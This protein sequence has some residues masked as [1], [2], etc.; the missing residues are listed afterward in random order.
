MDLTRRFRLDKLFRQPVLDDPTAL[1]WGI[2]LE[3]FLR[4]KARKTNV[5]I[6]N[7]TSHFLASPD[8]L[9]QEV[10]STVTIEELPDVGTDMP[11]PSGT[12]L[13]PPKS[14]VLPQTDVNKDIPPLNDAPLIDDKP[15]AT[16]SPAQR[17]P[18]TSNHIGDSVNDGDAFKGDDDDDAASLA[19]DKD[20]DSEGS[21][22]VVDEKEN[23]TSDAAV[24]VASGS[25]GSVEAPAD[26]VVVVDEKENDTS[27]AASR[28]KRRA[29][30]GERTLAK[31]QKGKAE[32]NLKEEQIYKSTQEAIGNLR[33]GMKEARDNGT[34]MLLQE[35]DDEI[36]RVNDDLNTDLINSCETVQDVLAVVAKF[37]TLKAH[38]A[39]CEK[40]MKVMMDSVTG[41]KS[42]KRSTKKTSQ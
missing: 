11:N 39:A 27:N 22:F 33:R 37:E 8:E 2:V 30:D 6:A 26:F 13:T 40:K 35:D 20:D 28:N 24:A 19:D 9:L 38:K 7:T 42:T 15:P 4:A 34:L 23:D 32:Y 14:P 21:D 10:G 41:Q 36:C 5:V 3:D 1:E 17:T 16:P 29:A 12:N 31:K 25:G 18:S